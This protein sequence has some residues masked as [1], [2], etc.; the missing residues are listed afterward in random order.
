MTKN[1]WKDYVFQKNKIPKALGVSLFSFVKNM[2]FLQGS[3]ST[4]NPVEA[5][6]SFLNLFNGR[7]ALEL[8][9]KKIS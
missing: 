4:G 3:A 9:E 8:S 2:S 1:H 5:H 7:T 6:N